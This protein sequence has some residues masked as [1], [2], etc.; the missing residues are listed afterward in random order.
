[1]LSEAFKAG[2]TSLS[3]PL[4]RREFSP[5]DLTRQLIAEYLTEQVSATE[6]ALTEALG[7]TPREVQ[8]ALAYLKEKELVVEQEDGYHLR[9]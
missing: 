6:A 4:P 7:L 9:A 5:E 8:T 3:L 2:V 1:M